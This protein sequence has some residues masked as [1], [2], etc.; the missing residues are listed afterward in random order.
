M[1][2]QNTE[3]RPTELINTTALHSADLKRYEPH[4]FPPRLISSIVDQSFQ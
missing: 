1:R 2:K 3:M 4:T